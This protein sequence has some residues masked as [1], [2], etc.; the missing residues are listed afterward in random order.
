MDLGRQGMDKIHELE[1]N[2]KDTVIIWRFK[3]RY[4]KIE[5]LEKGWCDKDL[6]LLHAAFQILVDFVEK[7]IPGTIIDWNWD[8]GHQKAWAEINS[9]YN[10]WTRIRPQRKS[11]V[12]YK[13]LKRPRFKFKKLKGKEFGELIR[14]D[15]RKYA[16]YYKAVKKEEE[17]EN[18][19]LNEDNGNLC[20]LISIRT[21]LWT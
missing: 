9:L 2:V 8:K 15:K 11:P 19:W 14:P 6:L 7:E 13:K 17:L 16:K 18:K 1:S 10:W 20:R 21:Y 12:D 5:G 3:M 4:L